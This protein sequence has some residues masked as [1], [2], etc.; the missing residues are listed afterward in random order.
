MPKKNKSVRVTCELE[1]SPSPGHKLTAKEA[2]KVEAAL[3]RVVEEVF[4][5]W[6]VRGMWVHRKSR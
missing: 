3:R 4:P 6:K 5:E 1:F 2:R